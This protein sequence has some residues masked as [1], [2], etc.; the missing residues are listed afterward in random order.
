M[1]RL[2]GVSVDILRDAQLSGVWVDLEERMMVLHVEAVRQR[3]EQFA[4]LGAVGICSN[5]LLRKKKHEQI[6][7]RLP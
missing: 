3:V 2:S 6:T 5:N 7:R 1:G 4:K